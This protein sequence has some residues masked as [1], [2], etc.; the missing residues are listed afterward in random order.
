MAPFHEITMPNKSYRQVSQWSGDEMKMLGWI[1]LG[2]LV[3]SLILP[4]ATQEF[5]TAK[6]YADTEDRGAVFK[7][8]VQCT[9]SLVDF[10][11]YAQYKEHMN[12]TLKCIKSS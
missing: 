12:Q 7:Q 3:A 9:R 8:A 2:A 4:R 10:H 11:I 1:I 6:E 5:L